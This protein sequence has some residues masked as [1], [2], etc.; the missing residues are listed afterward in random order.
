M[1]NYAENLTHLTY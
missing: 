1:T